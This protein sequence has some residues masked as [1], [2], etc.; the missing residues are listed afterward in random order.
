M[1][2]PDP[3]FSDVLFH[4][5]EI[6]TRESCIDQKALHCHEANWRLPSPEG[7]E[8]KQSLH[9]LPIYNSVSKNEFHYIKQKQLFDR[10][11]KN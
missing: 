2:E 7:E 1:N 6:L 11:K 8:K 9:Q 10:L 4:N 3:T 5:G